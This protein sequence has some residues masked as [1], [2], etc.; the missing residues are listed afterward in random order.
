MKEV[1]PIKSYKSIQDIKKKLEEELNYRDLLLFTSGINLGLRL[2]VLLT[3]K[4]WDMINDDGSIKSYIYLNE[5]KTNISNKLYL[6]EA[7]KYILLKYIIAYKDISKNKDN[8]LFFR[9]K[10]APLWILPITRR[11]WLNLIKKWTRDIWLSWGYGSHTFPKTRGYFARKNDISM[12]IIQN[13]L[14]QKSIRDT[15]KYIWI[16]NVEIENNWCKVNL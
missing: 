12:N 4:V 15:E 10:T 8:F 16:T 3:L 14:H 11:Q 5:K 7:I 13:K 6:N 1:E 9:K 2:G